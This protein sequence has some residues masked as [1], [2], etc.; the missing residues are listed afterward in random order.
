VHV[1]DLVEW[2][3]TA[4][5]EREAAAQAA[6]PGPWVTDRL[7]FVESTGASEARFVASA[8]YA[9]PDGSS[10]SILQADAEHIALNDPKAVLRRCAADRKLLHLHDDEPSTPSVL[11]G[12]CANCGWLRPCPTVRLLAEGYGYQ[13]A[14]VNG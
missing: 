5:G 7:C 13:E 12:Y 6:T 8:A 1:N 3:E 9:Y 2:L 4:I 14:T 10:D 11:D